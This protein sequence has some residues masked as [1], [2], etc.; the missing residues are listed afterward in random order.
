MKNSRWIIIGV[1]VIGALFLLLRPSTQAPDQQGT[2]RIAMPPWTTSPPPTYVAKVMLEDVLGL[3]VE[4][5]EVDIGVAFQA[6]TTDDFDLLVDAWMPNLHANYFESYGD[7]LALLGGP[8]YSGTELGWAVPAYVPV[9]S[10]SELN[11]Y[12][13]EFKGRVIGIDPGAGMQQTSEAIIEAYELDY[14]LTEGSEF[15]ML[16]AL[17]D[18]YRAEEW[19]VFIAW[20]PHFKFAQYDLKM[21]EEEKGFWSEDS[22][23]KVANLDFEERFPEAARLIS[24]WTMDLADIEVMINDI[25]V[26]ERNPEVVAREWVHANRELIDEW[27]RQ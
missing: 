27:L 21:L 1:L 18:A 9:N 19:V 24:K 20:R 15:A 5:Q 14:E 4:V 6:L 8:L 2:V 12:V 11:D 17:A 16:A 25:E 23:V 3:N 22:V 7:K 10:V 13:D 26:N